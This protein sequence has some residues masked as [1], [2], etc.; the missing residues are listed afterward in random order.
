[1][2]E[3]SVRNAE[4]VG[5]NPITSTVEKCRSEALSG[6]LPQR[7][8]SRVYRARHAWQPPSRGVMLRPPA[9]QLDDSGR[10]RTG[11]VGA[12]RT[13]GPPER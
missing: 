3:R 12:T 6:E 13:A 1:M 9:S 11:F 7:F 10:A 8:L 2:A 4:A 5:S